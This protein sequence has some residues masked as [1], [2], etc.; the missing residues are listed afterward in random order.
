MIF[1]STIYSTCSSRLGINEIVIFTMAVVTLGPMKV[2]FHYCHSYRLLKVVWL[3]ILDKASAPDTRSL[4]E[5]GRHL[6][7]ARPIPHLEHATQTNSDR[8]V[9]QFNLNEIMN[10]QRDLKISHLLHSNHRFLG[11]VQNRCT[12]ATFPGTISSLLAIIKAGNRNLLLP[13]NSHSI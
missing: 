7:Q 4:V 5:I 2:Y 11:M 3:L 12:C 9:N 6:L 10:S 13:M 8:F 1:N